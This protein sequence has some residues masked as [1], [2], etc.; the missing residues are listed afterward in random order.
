[1]IHYLSQRIVD[2]SQTATVRAAALTGFGGLCR[3]Y[4][5]DT[6]PLL[7]SAGLPLRA[8]AEPDR[9]LSA[10]A[11]N[12]ALE[13]AA[14]LSGAEDFGLRLAELRGFS[15]LGPVTVLARDEPDM[16]SALAIFIAHLPLHNEALAVALSLEGDVAILMCHILTA[17][18]KTQATDVA[19]AMLHRILRQLLG[20]T[21]TPQMVALERPA[22]VRPG[23][24]ERVFGRQVAFG[25]D[26][27]GIVFDP[28]DLERPNLLAEADLRRYT[29]DLRQSLSSQQDEPLSARV[30]RQQRTMLSEQ[31]CTA[32]AVAARL[33]LARRSLDRGLAKEATSFHALLDAVRRDAALDL[34]E[35]SGRSMTEIAGMLGFASAAAFNAWFAARWRL[36]PGRWRL[37]QKF[38]AESAAR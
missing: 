23:H 8:E 1:L 38:L 26:F 30:Q 22:P 37:Q 34:V 5:I 21:W 2:L 10:S 9:R 17:G 32:S 35:G 4:G 16:R 11:V 14:D 31:R 33:G 12:R 27:S 25:Q 7:R 13:H 36:P 19:V 24:F 6:A 3:T 18:R 20:S 15:N 29:A 28:A